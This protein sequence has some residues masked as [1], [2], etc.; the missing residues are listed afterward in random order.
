[1][2]KRLIIIVG[3]LHLVMGCRSL[4]FLKE[5]TNQTVVPVKVE[6]IMVSPQAF[7]R[8]EVN[9]AMDLHLHSAARKPWFTMHGD[10]RDLRNI[11]WKVKAKTLQISLDSRFPKHGP[12]TIELGTQELQAIAYHG[13]GNVS[14]Q[15]LHFNYL[16]LDIANSK[17]TQLTGRLNL[18]RAELS[19]KGSV[20]IRDHSNHAMHLILR[21]RVHVKVVGKTAPNK[22]EMSDSSFLNLPHVHTKDLQ[23][24]MQNETCAIL[25][26]NVD[27]ALIKLSG[28]ARFNG[29]F[30]HA[31]EMF[32]KT[33]HRSLALIYVVK[34]QHALAVDDSNI[35]YYHLPTYVNNFME[36]NGAILD[37]GA[38]FIL[39]HPMRHP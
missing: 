7:N 18:H 13:K 32:V 34:R 3:L 2:K 19:D 15:R 11:V 24:A 29:R 16:D 30:L 6:T 36:N 33:N 27:W 10:T 28:R 5:S 38:E 26:G 9:G 37:L 22:I 23:I 21:D 39:K 25:S 35:Y 4:N 12:L 20:I 1:M 31:R 14:G 17:Q 8:L